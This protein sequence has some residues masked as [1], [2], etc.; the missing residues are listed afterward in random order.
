M[1]GGLRETVG[2]YVTY[3]KTNEGEEQQKEKKENGRSISI[4]D[5]HI[6]IEKREVERKVIFKLLKNNS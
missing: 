1:T 5:S 3:Q 6:E 2:K 4:K